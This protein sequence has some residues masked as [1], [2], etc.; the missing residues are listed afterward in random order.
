MAE[1]RPL[2]LVFEDLHWADDDLLD[3]VDHL[4]EW[5][6]GVPILVVGTARPE[7]LERRPAWGG[8]SSTR[9]RFARATHGGAHE[10]TRRACSIGDAGSPAEAQ[11]DL[12][13]RVGGNP[14]YTEQYVQMR[15]RGGDQVDLPDPSRQGVIAARLDLL[16]PDQKALFKTRPCSAR[17]FWLGAS[18]TDG[19]ESEAEVDSACAGS[20]GI[21]APGAHRQSQ[22]SR[23]T[24][25]ASARPRRRLRPDPKR[26]RAG[27]NMPRRGVDRVARPSRRARRNARLPLPLGLG[28]RP[29]KQGAD[30]GTR[31]PRA[32]RSA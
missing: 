22:T 19:T 17:V 7:L 31:K 6:S 14:L 9:R 5:A 32:A 25:P 30:R 16:P 21:R 27:R 15:T 3:F 18:S 8:G 23:S 11:A 24:L 2:V 26:T 13:A 28:A 20:Q 12:L 10:P 1:H 29:G 4:V